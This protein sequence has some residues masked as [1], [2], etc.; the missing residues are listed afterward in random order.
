[1]RAEGVC[2]PL[3]I[4]MIRGD[5]K[6]FPDHFSPEVTGDPEVSMNEK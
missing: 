2:K 3:G 5:L 1:M 6:E 4:V